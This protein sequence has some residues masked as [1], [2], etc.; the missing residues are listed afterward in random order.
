MDAHWRLARAYGISNVLIYYKLSDM[1]NVGDEGSAMRALA[2][3]LLAN[4]ETRT[5]LRQE[6]DQFGTTAKSL[7]LT[8][9][10]RSMLPTRRLVRYDW[11]HG[12]KSLK[13]P[14]GIEGFRRNMSVGGR[15]EVIVV[16]SSANSCCTVGWFTAARVCATGRAPRR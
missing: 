1:E 7:G 13:V 12:L 4:A 14:R 2:N 10:G 16:Q 8:S 5:I 9:T 6:S 3:S 15:S 11:P